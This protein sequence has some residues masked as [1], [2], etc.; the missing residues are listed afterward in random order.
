MGLRM[1]MR[2]CTLAAL[3]V[4]C[5]QTT[6]GLIVLEPDTTSTPASRSPF[7]LETNTKSA[8]PQNANLVVYYDTIKLKSVIQMG[9]PAHTRIPNQFGQGR[10]VS[11][12]DALR[13][14][15]PSSIS[16]DC[17][18][19]PMPHVNWK[20]D[21][22]WLT[23]VDNL[24]TDN[25]MS[26]VMDWS[27][28]KMTVTMPIMPIER[29]V[30]NSS[31]DLKTAPVPLTPPIKAPIVDPSPFSVNKSKSPGVT[32]TAQFVAPKAVPVELW[33]ADAGKTLR[34]VL[35]DWAKKAKWSLVWDASVDYPIEA[36]FVQSGDYLT[37]V[38]KTVEL[39]KTADYPLYGEAYPE[40]RLVIITATKRVAG[41]K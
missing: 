35:T 33:K 15:A 34:E 5:N 9:M 18:S 22:N 13:Q 25:N 37:A 2:L 31:S 30:A 4:F 3:L 17:C 24:L 12:R 28:N 23:A 8:T 27:I 6:A 26:A 14:L 32:S 7:L 39:Y 41:V 29:P 38:Q 1:K 40:Q 36:G 20:S 19:S 11:I 21:G 16:I 10:G